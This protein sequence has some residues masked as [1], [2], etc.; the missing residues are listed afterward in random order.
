MAD[1]AHAAVL[2]PRHQQGRLNRDVAPR[3]IRQAS[4]LAALPIDKDALQA[5]AGFT[6]R[7]SRVTASVGYEG[8]FSDTFD[9]HGVRANISIG[10]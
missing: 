4:I 7:G 8:S 6:Y 5:G 1:E 2:I 10:F 9:S 3:A